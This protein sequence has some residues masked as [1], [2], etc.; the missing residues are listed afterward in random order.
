VKDRLFALGFV[1]LLFLG[2]G[3]A[4]V[5]AGGSQYSTKTK[6]EKATARITECATTGFSKSRTV[7]C[8]GSWVVGGRLVGGGGHV[9][10]GTVEG[11]GHDDVGKT[12]DV[13]LDGDKA[14]TTSLA[15]PIFLVCFGVVLTAI[16]LLILRSSLR[17]RARPR[18][19]EPAESVPQ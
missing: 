8:S 10:L 9:V 14:S 18:A 19:G 16:G 2:P 1:L 3:V 7:R 13:R 11:A 12:I 4:M 5:V 15:T 17:R 6:G